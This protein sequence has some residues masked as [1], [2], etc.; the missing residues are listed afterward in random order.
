M[1]N[2]FKKHVKSF[3]IQN[4]NGMEKFEGELINIDENELNELTTMPEL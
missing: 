4:N 1:F 3:E 2:I